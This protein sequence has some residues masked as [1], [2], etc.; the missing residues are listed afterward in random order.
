MPRHKS[1]SIPLDQLAQHEIDFLI[2]KLA[3]DKAY[4]DNDDPIYAENEV[5]RHVNILRERFSKNIKAAKAGKVKMTMITAE[6]CGRAKGAKLRSPR[7]WKFR[8]KSF[9]NGKGKLPYTNEHLLKFGFLQCPEAKVLTLSNKVV[10]PMLL[11]RWLVTDNQKRVMEPIL[12]LASKLIL[13]PAS[14]RFLHAII[15]NEPVKE[16]AASRIWDLPMEEISYG[17]AQD[18]PIRKL[19]RKVVKTLE[20]LGEQVSWQL[21][22]KDKPHWILSKGAPVMEAFTIKRRY[23]PQYQHLQ[24]DGKRGA[25]FFIDMHFMALLENLDLDAR[26]APDTEVV[27]ILIRS[28]M[29]LAVTLCH[30]TAHAVSVIITCMCLI[31][32]NRLD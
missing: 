21:F 31:S 23:V 12:R 1:K 4:E 27:D 29:K 22:D 15:F 19:R 3:Q 24:G 2:Q 14:I 25:D 6:Q 13:S 7:E 18:V 5:K 32:T 26:K 17:A 11:D 16:E 28:R 8:K 9:V 30:E 10:A 20:E